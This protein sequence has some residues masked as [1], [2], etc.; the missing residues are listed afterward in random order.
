MNLGSVDL[1]LLVAL[2]ALLAE[3]S[4]T[5]A[6]QRVGISQPGMSNAL[7]R[8]RKLVGDPLLVREGSALA[9]TARGESLI[10]PVR[11]ALTTIELALEGRTEFNPAT[12]TGTIDVSCSDYSALVLIAPL[13]KRLAVEAPG[14]TVRLEPRGADPAAMLRSGE[15]DLVIEPVAI[16][17][18]CGAASERLFEDQWL[19]CVWQGNDKVSDALD[20]ETYLSL[21]H[22]VYSMGAGRPASLV[23][24]FLDR[25]GLQRNVEL[26]VESFFL[27]PLLLEGTDLVTL[28]LGR[29]VPWL[30]RA[31][32]IRVFEPPMR[33]PAIEQAMWWSPRRAADPFLAWFRGRVQQIAAEIT[34]EQRDVRQP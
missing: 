5:R 19:C 6:A 17:G 16:M 10:E 33:I 13:M 12:D 2:D 22:I 32:D 31:A 27:A 25:T 3:R 18:D 1:N 28:V 7:S 20:L 30:G 14:V 34:A 11:A 21:S 29:A 9:L 26:M 8:L 4:V 15:V 24:D 23:D